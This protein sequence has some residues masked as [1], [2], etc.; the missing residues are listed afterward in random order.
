MCLRSERHSISV[1]FDFFQFLFYFTTLT[2]DEKIHFYDCIFFSS[3]SFTTSAFVYAFHYFHVEFLII[4]AQDIVVR[5][6]CY[7]SYYLHF[8]KGFYHLSTSNLLI[9]AKANIKTLNAWPIF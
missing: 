2:Y 9:Y 8:I 1:S 6:F 4:I 5:D 3:F 7:V